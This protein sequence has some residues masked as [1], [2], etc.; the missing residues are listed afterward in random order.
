MANPDIYEFIKPLKN[1]PVGHSKGT[2]QVSTSVGEFSD[3][4]SVICPVG[5]LSYR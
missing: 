3:F 2:I 4:L 5:Q 1:A